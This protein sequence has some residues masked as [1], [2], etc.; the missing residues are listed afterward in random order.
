MEYR[1]LGNSGLKVSEISLGGNTFGWHIDEQASINLIHGALDM[2]INY[3]DTAD[4]YDR[5]TSEKYVGK[6]LED[7]RSQVILASKFG[8]RLNDGPN[9]VGGSRYYIMKAVDASLKR[10]NTDYI[11]LYQMHR[12]DPTTPIE[13]TLRALDDLVRAGK[14]RYI[15]CTNFVAW[16]LVEALCASKSSNLESFTTVQVRYNLLE[17]NLGKELLPCC[18][19][20]GI[21][22]IP[23]APL[24]AGFLTGKYHRNDIPANARLANPQALYGNVVCEANF[25]KLEKLEKFVAE[26]GHSILELAISWLL[27]HKCLSTIIAGA[28]TIEQVSANIDAAGWKLT[29]E[30][31]AELDQIC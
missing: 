2:G 12:P 18:E 31:M 27:S 28:T 29:A 9:E 8:L 1:N 13:E 30:E 20:Y 19:K 3:I 16:Q 24:A 15:G 4:F 26:H 7:K 17:R 14:V 25:D 10:L 11:D 21:G 5:G 23:W 22:L 6:A